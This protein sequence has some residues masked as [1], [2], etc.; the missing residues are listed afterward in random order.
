MKARF[1]GLRIIAA[2]SKA[3][4][5]VSLLAGLGLGALMANATYYLPFLPPAAPFSSNSL[6]GAA[7][8][9]LPFLMG[10]LFL[11]ATGAIL[12]VLLA[13]ECNTR[14]PAA[15]RPPSEPAGSNETGAPVGP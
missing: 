3:V 14:V 13:I 11:Y 4:A 5:W 2:V 7:L 8:T 1:R 10:F 6:L 15:V 9:L 12:Q